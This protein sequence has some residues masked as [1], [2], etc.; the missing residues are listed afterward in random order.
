MKIKLG[1]FFGG[2]SVEHEVSVITALQAVAALDKAKYEVVPVYISKDD[3]MYVGDG[4]SDIEKYKDIPKLLKTCVRVV[5]LNENGKAN[6]VRVPSKMFS[7]NVM[8]EIEVAMLLGHGTN[9]EDGALQGTFETLGI[10]YT[11]CGVLSAACGMDK[12]V[13]KILLKEA[14]IPVLDA[15]KV[16]A[17]DYIADREK[18]FAEI[19]ERFMDK[20]PVIVKPVNLGSSIG[21]KFATCRDSLVDALEHAFLFA[22]EVLVERAI[23]NLREINVSVLGDAQRAVASVCEEPLSN[24]QILDFEEKYLRQGKKSGGMAT[25]SRKIPAD[26][27]KNLSEQIKEFGISAFKALGCSGVARVDFMLDVDN[28]NSLYLTEINTLPGSLS[29]YLWEPTG[30]KYPALLDE[31]VALALKRKRNRQS[32]NYSFTSN[33][34]SNYNASAR[35]GGLKK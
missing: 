2:R 34:L 3:K 28:D 14:G 19:F 24:K 4:L 32:V 16:S 5:L 22:E 9:V 25:L 11:G 20:S 8:G 7:K 35:K 1:V 26:I 12:Y 21:V 6:L 17:V 29:F 10:A 13:M 30:L 15:L 23:T 33:I 31:L 18:T 27:P